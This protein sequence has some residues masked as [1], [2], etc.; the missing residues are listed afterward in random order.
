[1]LSQDR[2]RFVNGVKSYPCRESYG[3]AFV[4][5]GD[6][7]LAERAPF[8]DIPHFSDPA[9]K[10]RVLD[11]RIR[12]HYS[13]MHENLMDMNHQFLHR[14][15]MGVISTIL[16]ATEKGE[17]WIETRYTFKRTGGKQP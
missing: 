10:T 2:E 4:F 3:F 13:F 11:R 1:Y 8:P 14:S 5:T 17:G 16:L 7:K 6:P 12:C 9:Y 15:L